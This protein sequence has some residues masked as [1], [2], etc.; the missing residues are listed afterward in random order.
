VRILGVAGFAV[1][2]AVSSAGAANAAVIDW[3]AWTGATTGETTG[4]ATGT[5]GSVGISYA[6]EVQSL[7]LNYPS[8]NPS[9]SYVGGTIGNAPLPSDNI[10]QIFG[11]PGSGTDTITFSKAVTNPTFAIWSLGQGGTIAQFNFNSPFTIEAGGPSVEYGGSTVT[12]T[13]NIIFGAE[14]NGSLQFNGTFTSISWT[15]PVAENW[16]GFTVGVAA[17]PEPSTWAMMILGFLGVG[18]MAYR[19]KSIPAFRL[20]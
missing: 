16:Y 11:G 19:R 13:G 6:G 10:I 9:T 3:T 5:A 2:L 17:V 7:Q 4:T 18:F 12:S 8:W 15:N 14:G 1:A 20:A